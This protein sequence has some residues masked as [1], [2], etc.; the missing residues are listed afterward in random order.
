M[1][2]NSFTFT[3]KTDFDPSNCGVFLPGWGFDG[4]I[5]KL[6]EDYRPWLTPAAWLAPTETAE[7]LNAFLDQKKIASI[8]L[9]GWSMGAYQAIDFALLFPAR[10]KALYLLGLRQAWPPVEIKQIR[11]ELHADPVR[12]MRTFY[13]KCFLGHKADYQ[14]FTDSLEESYLAA[15]DSARLEAGL[16]YLHD[17]PMAA[18]TSRLAG[19]D[20]PVFLLNG[21]KDLIAPPAEIPVIPG[22]ASQLI[23]TAG[24]PV[25]LDKSCPMDWHRKKETIRLKFSRSAAT[26]D[27]HATLQQEVADRLATMLPGKAPATILETGCGTGNFT[28]LLQKRY[29][30]ARLTALDFAENM[31]TQASAKL[32]DVPTV[33]FTCADAELFLKEAPDSFDLITSNATMHWFDNLEQSSALMAERLTDGGNLVCSIFGPKTMGELQAGLAKIHG[34]EV[35]MPSALF[36][37]QAELEKIF[38]KLFSKVEVEEWLLTRHYPN[39]IALLRSIS[40]TGTA[41]WHPGHHLLNRAHMMELEH[42]FKE[43]LGDCRISYQ[44]FM[45]KCQK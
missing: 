21:A 36:P 6:A 44:I 1:R 32:G 27:Q 40:K 5:V 8:I 23:K 22:A 39:L 26:Y 7:A 10:V 12:F 3:S 11:T 43:S 31:L 33:T 9:T 14:K 29:P 45:V 18:K 38:A 34:R 20:L 2:D 16:A 42:W 25:F 35:A 15:L 19:L 4:R 24:H 30:A 41:G 13:R 17:F 28:V 37:N